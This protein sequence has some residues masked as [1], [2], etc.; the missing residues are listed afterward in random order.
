MLLRRSF[1][2]SLAAFF[3]VVLFAAVGPAPAQQATP[4]LHAAWEGNWDGS[5]ANWS[6]MTVKVN[7]SNA[8]VVYVFAGAPAYSTGTTTDGTKLAFQ[9]GNANFTFTVTPDGKTLQ[10]T[11]SYPQGANSITMTRMF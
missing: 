3:T 2:I 4:P 1:A 7:G 11:R 5:R 8:D 9:W 6:V 10:G